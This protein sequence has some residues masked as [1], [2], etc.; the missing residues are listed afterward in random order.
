MAMNAGETKLSELVLAIP[1][2]ERLFGRKFEVIYW[3]H[4]LG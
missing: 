3:S 2:D 4:T 1:D